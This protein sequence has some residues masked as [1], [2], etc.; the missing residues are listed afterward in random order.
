[1]TSSKSHH[2]VEVLK[3][4]LRHLETSGEWAQD[5]TAVIELKQI[6]QRRIDLELA[7]PAN[8][9]NPI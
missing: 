9:N 6:L 5:D 1:M 2:L 7:V 4:I 8:G 3:A